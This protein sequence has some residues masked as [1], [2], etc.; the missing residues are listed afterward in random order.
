MQNK[1]NVKYVWNKILKNIE[2][3]NIVSVIVMVILGVIV[4]FLVNGFF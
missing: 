3:K 2:E 4:Y 1:E